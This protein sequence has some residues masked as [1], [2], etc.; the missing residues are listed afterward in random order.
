MK[1][2]YI[3]K[4]KHSDKLNVYIDGSN[5]RYRVGLAAVTVKQCLQNCLNV[6]VTVVTYYELKEIDLAFDFIL[7]SAKCRYI[8]FILISSL[9]YKD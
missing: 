3:L 9:S 1:L 7:E 5:D 8:S 2:K 6:N 4:V